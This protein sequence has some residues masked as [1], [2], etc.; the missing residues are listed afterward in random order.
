MIL[1]IEAGRGVSRLALPPTRFSGRFCD[2]V[3]VYVDGVLINSGGAFLYNLGLDE[4]EELE[5]LSESEAVSRFGLSAGSGA[6]AI[7]T[8]RGPG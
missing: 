3:A 7:T 1:C 4:I 6:L 8:K 2:M 5:L